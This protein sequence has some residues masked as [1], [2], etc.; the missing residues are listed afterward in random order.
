MPG[1]R[2]NPLEFDSSLFDRFEPF[3]APLGAAIV[4]LRSTAVND[5]FRARYTRLARN[6]DHFPR[7]IHSDFGEGVLFGM[8]ALAVA[9]L[10]ELAI[11]VREPFGGSVVP[12]AVD[13][14]HVF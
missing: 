4:Q 14:R 11:V 1:G 6:E 7:V 9:G 8:H 3:V 5:E 12:E 10:V 13:L 2:S